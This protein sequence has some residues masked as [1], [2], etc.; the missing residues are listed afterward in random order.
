MPSFNQITI[1]GHLARDPEL[2]FLQNQTAVCSFSVAT[3]HK[4]K[5]SSGEEREDVTFIDCTAWGKRGEVINQY[6]KKGNP[7]FIAG[8]LRQETWE[9]KNG[10][11]KRSKH[12]VVVENFQF[13]GGGGRDNQDGDDQRP[14][15]SYPKNRDTARTPATTGPVYD[16]QQQFA[17]DDIPF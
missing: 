12:T 16:D 15:N 14:G 3:N 11:G 8:R 1:I 17:D 2:K 9:D 6:L 5:T 7:I 13:L 10:G 4:W